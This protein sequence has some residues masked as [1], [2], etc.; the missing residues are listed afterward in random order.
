MV[1][2][3]RVYEHNK[4]LCQRIINGAIG[5]AGHLIQWKIENNKNTKNSNKMG[6]DQPQWQQN[7]YIT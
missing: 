3:V 7:L 5:I 2:A 4:A 6:L 1:S